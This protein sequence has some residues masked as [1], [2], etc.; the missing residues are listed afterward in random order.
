MSRLLN[1]FFLTLWCVRIVTA[2][3]ETEV[4]AQVCVRN[5][6][7]FELVCAFLIF[8]PSGSCSA[9]LMPVLRI[10]FI[11][12]FVIWVR[13]SAPLCWLLC[14]RIAEGWFLAADQVLW[15]RI[16]GPEPAY[17]L[18]GFWSIKCCMCRIPCT[19]IWC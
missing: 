17:V 1:S 4:R 14:Y 11:L 5:I 7:K 10:G 13:N 3:M 15:W 18:T 6:K 19:R 9:C 2:S 16:C 8:L 12:Y